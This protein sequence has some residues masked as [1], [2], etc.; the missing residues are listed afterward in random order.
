MPCT[1]FSVICVAESV[2]LLVVDISP[3]SPVVLSPVAVDVLDGGGGGGVTV[4][5]IWPAKADI[6]SMRV[7]ANAAQSCLRYLIWFSSK[8]L[9]ILEPWCFCSDRLCWTVRKCSPDQTAQDLISRA[10]S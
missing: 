6:A 8:G 7:N 2:T 9:L 10:T 1:R 3:V 4:V 5:D